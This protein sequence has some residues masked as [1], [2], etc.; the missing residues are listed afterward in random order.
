[1]L[2]RQFPTSITKAP[3]RSK[4]GG[5]DKSGAARACDGGEL[6]TR[7]KCVLSG[8][9]ISQLRPMYVEYSQAKTLRES[10]V[11]QTIRL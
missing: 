10:G 2:F 11:L 1:M 8:N 5:G 3:L 9:Q 7:W 4:T 6:D